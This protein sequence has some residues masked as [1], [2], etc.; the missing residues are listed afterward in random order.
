MAAERTHTVADVVEHWRR[1]GRDDARL[2]RLAEDVKSHA[3]L[4]AVK[5][6]AAAQRLTQLQRV[7]NAEGL[8]QQIRLLSDY[9]AG[10]M[11][12]RGQVSWLSVQEN[13]T[14]K[15]NAR[16]LRRPD[17]AAWPPG[18]WY[19]GYYL[20]QFRSFVNGLKGDAT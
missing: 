19:N 12:M 8:D 3:G 4:P 5:G 11:R 13:G 15:V 2:G 10:V 1:F 18:A 20:P 16:T 7:A 9:H 6:S 17:P 14:I